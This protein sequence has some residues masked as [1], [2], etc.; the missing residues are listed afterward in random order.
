MLPKNKPQVK[1]QCYG[2]PSHNSFWGCHLGK[3]DTFLWLRGMK[4]PRGC[5][6]AIYSSENL[7]IY[8]ISINLPHK[9]LSFGSNSN[10]EDSKRLN[11]EM[12]EDL[13]KKKKRNMGD[14]DNLH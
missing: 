6:A 1:G 2:A 8:G 7:K 3:H 13:K 12:K 14:R 11:M 4:T 10:M 9:N 5:K